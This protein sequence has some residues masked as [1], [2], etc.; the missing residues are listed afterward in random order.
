M[1]WLT[2]SAQRGLPAQGPNRLDVF[3]KKDGQ[4]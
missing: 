2:P 3:N 4:L 1:V